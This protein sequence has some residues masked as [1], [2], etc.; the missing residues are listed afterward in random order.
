MEREVK[1]RPVGKVRGQQ[2]GMEEVGKQA[3]VKY[4]RWMIKIKGKRTCGEID[5]K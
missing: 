3:G 4:T 1:T 2:G 5:V